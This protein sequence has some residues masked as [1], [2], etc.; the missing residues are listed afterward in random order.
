MTTYNL[1][2]LADV[3]L[4]CIKEN[5]KDIEL[6]NGSENKLTVENIP[7]CT[8]GTSKGTL[9]IKDT[10]EDLSLLF[11]FST[12][13]EKVDFSNLNVKNIKTLDRAC[14]SMLSLK[15]VVLSG[16]FESLEP[17]GLRRF[18]KDSENLE[19]L[20]IKDATFK[21]A[22]DLSSFAKG[23]HNLK[24][25]SLQNVNFPDLIELPFAFS[26]CKSLEVCNLSST[27]MPL[28]EDLTGIFE[29]C[30]ELTL[31]IPPKES[32]PNLK[33]AEKMFSL[34]RSE[35]DEVDLSE[36]IVGENV[37]TND[38]FESS[39]FEGVLDISGITLTNPEISKNFLNTRVQND[40]RV[41][42]NPETARALQLMD[43]GQW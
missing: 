1:N 20:I 23:C 31:F 29:G 36:F 3:R 35:V 42:A 15:E 34:V 13:I 33:I 12:S 14:G 5:I 27:S 43:E 21:G 40:L 7:G 8:E 6:K 30:K 37:V 22:S 32:F 38:M 17:E 11:M 39:T 16:N 41:R 18:V 26:D 2:S 24:E 25:V 4:L 28:V 10:E 9:E 19:T